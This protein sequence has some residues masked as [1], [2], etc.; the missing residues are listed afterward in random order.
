MSRDSLIR[1]IDM[2]QEQIFSK[3]VEDNPEILNLAKDLNLVG[4]RIGSPMGTGEAETDR[5]DKL[6]EIAQR[7]LIQG[8]IYTC[9]QVVS[10]LSEGLRISRERAVNGLEMMKS[11]GV[12]IQSSGQGISLSM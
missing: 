1:F 3:M 2:T 7:T 10:L 5:R 4:L 9:E 6:S 11:C 8:R 12:L